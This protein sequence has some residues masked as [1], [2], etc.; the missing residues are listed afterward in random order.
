MVV[1]PKCLLHHILSL[2]TYISRENREFVS[3]I[4]VQF[5]MNANSRIRFGLEIVFVCLYITPSDY[6]HC[7]NLTEYI[8]L[9][10]CLS[11]I[12]CRVCKIKHIFPVIRYTMH[13]T[14]SFQFTHFPCDDWGNIHVLSSSNRTIIHCLGLG[15]ETM[16]CAVCLY[17]LTVLSRILARAVASPQYAWLHE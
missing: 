14:V 7:A 3:I 8:E 13:G 17:V 2:I 11:D 16:V 4:T 1:C 9:I 5:M 6:H 12:L 10:K 15:H